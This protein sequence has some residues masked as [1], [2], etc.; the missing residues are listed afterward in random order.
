MHQS[1]FISSRLA[2]HSVAADLSSALKTGADLIDEAW[3][4][5]ITEQLSIPETLLPALVR[6]GAPLVVVGADAAALTGLRPGTPIITGATDGCAAQLG[7][8]A[9]TPGEWNSV[10]GTT[11]VLKGVSA[12]I[13]DDPLGVVYSHK[14]PDGQCLPG[15]ASSSGAGIISR[16]FAV[17]DLPQLGQAAEAF[18]PGATTYPLLSPG[19]RFPF[20]SPHAE[21]FSIGNPSTDEE[22][23]AAI[24][25]G[26]AFVERLCFDYLGFLGSDASGRILLTGGATRSAYW[27][28]VR[29]D[30]LGRTVYLPDNAKPALG[31]AVLAAAGVSGRSAARVAKQMVTMS[32]TIEPR[33]AYIDRFGA[34][35]LMFLSALEERGWLQHDVANYA[36][37]NL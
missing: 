19:E 9:L 14:G 21:A 5:G 10:V 12:S 18:H 22:R 6:S 11:L 16:E 3:D 27:S 23:Y 2:G 28:Q 13:I 34:P 25:Q 7:A 32:T 24:L 8:G 26:L 35:Y 33:S 20:N 29:A 37:T 31:A 15:G 36:R 30:V 1:D 17:E 4:A